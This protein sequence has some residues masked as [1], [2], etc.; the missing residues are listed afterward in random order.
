MSQ[1]NE[2]L[3]KAF[4]VCFCEETRLKVIELMGKNLDL[5]KADEYVTGLIMPFYEPHKNEM[6]IDAFKHLMSLMRE[7]IDGFY[8]LEEGKDCEIKIG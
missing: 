2:N 6:S 4:E 5:I 8:K 1:L 3:Q 7:T